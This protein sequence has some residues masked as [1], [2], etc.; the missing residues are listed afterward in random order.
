MTIPS[1]LNARVAARVLGWKAGK[2]CNAGGAVFSDGSWHCFAHHRGTMGQSEFDAHILVDDM[3]A[4]DMS[5][6]DNIVAM[7]LYFFRH[8]DQQARTD[9]NRRL[10]NITPES[11]TDFAWL[12]C[13]AIDSIKQE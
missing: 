9:M 6:N 1:D 12:F 10:L 8:A 2:K 3:P 5:T 7:M 13:L 4:P 11:E